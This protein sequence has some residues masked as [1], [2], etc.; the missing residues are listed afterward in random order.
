[1]S[2]LIIYWAALMCGSL[3]HDAKDLFFEVENTDYLILHDR[4]YVKVID[5]MHKMI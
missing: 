4:L 3:C 5:N 1:M 2:I